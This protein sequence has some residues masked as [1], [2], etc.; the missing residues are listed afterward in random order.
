MP[1]KLAAGCFL[2]VLAVGI[3]AVLLAAFPTAGRLL[4]WGG[5][6]VWLPWYIGRPHKS[7]QDTDNRTPPPKPEPE[8]PS[9][10]LVR[11]VGVGGILVTYQDDSQ[12]YSVDRNRT[13]PPPGE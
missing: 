2:V 4:L 8:K 9:N 10:K 7:V 11:T 12:R 6:A 5:A 1:S 3:L 13:A